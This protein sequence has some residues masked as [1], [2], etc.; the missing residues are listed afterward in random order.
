MM[1]VL[2]ISTGA[3]KSTPLFVEIQRKVRSVMPPRPQSQ[4][5]ARIT[6]L[7][8]AGVKT[9]ASPVALAASVGPGNGRGVDSASHADPP[10]GTRQ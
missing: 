10:A 6:T 5:D 7:L 3:L 9:W 8:A 2:P 4:H 1:R